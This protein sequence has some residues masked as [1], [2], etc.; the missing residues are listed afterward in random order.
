MRRSRRPVVITDAEE[1]PAD[2][3][4]RRQTRYIVMMTVRA[5]CLVLAA[6]LAM[7]RVPLLGLWV[8]IC[9]VGAVLLPWLAVML[10]NDRAPKPEHRLRNRFHAAREP[11]KPTSRPA[12]T[13][14]ENPTIIDV[15]P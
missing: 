6:V 11:E 8:S 5:G 2:E 4:R 1:S 7:A 14:R 3:L 13:Q 10:A 12:I 9:L 15:E